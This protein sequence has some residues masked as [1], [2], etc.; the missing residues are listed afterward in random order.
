MGAAVAGAEVTSALLVKKEPPV[1]APNPRKEG[2][3]AGVPNM[4]GVLVVAPK[5]VGAA[6]KFSV[7]PKV[8]LPKAAAELANA[9]GAVEV[10]KRGVVLP[11]AGVELP[12]AGVELPNAGVELPKMELC[13]P[14]AGAGV[15][16]PNR[17]GVV[18]LPNTDVLEAPKRLVVAEL[19]KALEEAPNNEVEVLPKAG[20]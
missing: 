1:L 5:G 3:L 12:K 19:P 15:L 17:E 11:K 13:A 10:P 8:V 16:A 2:L 20:V 4:D 14:K 6:P 9:E 18:V 7:D